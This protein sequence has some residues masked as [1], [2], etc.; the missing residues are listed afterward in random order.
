MGGAGFARGPAGA[1]PKLECEEGSVR[2]GG[3]VAG[4]SQDDV[5]V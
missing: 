2:E 5:E 3:G 4:V 1:F